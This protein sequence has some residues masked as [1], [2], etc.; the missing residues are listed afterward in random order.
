[1]IPAAIYAR[2]STEDQAERY[3]LAGQLHELRAAAAARG[4]VI[5]SGMEFVDDGHSGATIDR[6]AL[7]RLREVAKARAVD[8]I[9]VHDPDRL[10]RRLAHQLVLLEDLERAGVRV[11]FLSVERTD[12][13]EGRLLLNVRGAIAEYEREKIKDRTLR[14]KREKARRGLVVGGPV[15]F[16][17]R[18]DAG[19]AGGLAIREDQAAIVRL[20]YA[21][22]VDAGRS[23]RGLVL[24][25]RASGIPPARGAA[26]SKTS[27]RRLLTDPLY[28]GQAYF[29]RRARTG[30]SRRWR[31]EA[32]W[33]VVA[34]PA[35][36]TADLWAR[37]AA[38]LADNKTAAAGRPA[39]R[40]YLLRGLLRCG[41]CG[42]ALEGLPSHG[43][44]FYRCAGRQR[45][46]EPRC[47]APLRA[48]D[49]LEA[50]LWAAVT[51]LL[52]QP[53]VLTAKV[54][55][56]QLAAGVRDV[57]LRSEVVHLTAE[58]GRL[59][60]QEQRT[61]DL[62]V[63]ADLEVPG[64]RERL[65]R[66]RARRRAVQARLDQA[67]AASTRTQDAA[68]QQGAVQRACEAVLLGLEA[69]PPEVRQQIL[70]ALIDRITVSQDHVTVEGLL[71]SGPGGLESSR[72]STRSAQFQPRPAFR[73]VVPM[74][75]R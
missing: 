57:E 55:A 19:S 45:L 7:H 58:L 26:W 50:A 15:P 34:V 71:P 5:P 74:G 42:R 14:G 28:R 23:I 38:R 72:P 17:Y 73:L 12:G 35:I 41:S 69:A 49:R 44:R 20:L 70:R 18:L 8:V 67:Q 39:S 52:R 75:A 64:L 22:L 60:R 56:W 31:P 46:A 29:N 1:V 24:E 48:A 43:R 16:G 10:S 68:A 33:I 30:S 32:D 51:G 13:A 21:G 2:V 9:L 66:L 63:E 47:T 53:Q 59:T 3:G 25:L 4:Y 40:V 36:V 61:L 27:V 65:E 37:A 54:E 62:Y 11:E 6:P